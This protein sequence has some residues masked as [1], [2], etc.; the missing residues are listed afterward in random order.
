MPAPFAA[1]TAAALVD[2]FSYKYQYITSVFLS[3]SAFSEN[4]GSSNADA[5]P[6]ASRSGSSSEMPPFALCVHKASW[7]AI[8]A[9][10]P[11]RAAK[12]A[13]SSSPG[14]AAS[15]IRDLARSGWT[16]S[17]LL[18]HPRQLIRDGLE[19]IA[20]H[21]PAFGL[22]KDFRWHPWRQ[23]Q[24]P[25]AVYLLLLQGDPHIVISA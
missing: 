5:N 7:P 20:Q 3:A 4:P 15:V 23:L 1:A 17:A 14:N 19:E 2:I 18:E 16:G 25:E 6:S 21:R 9:L 24:V 10:R 13:R 22:Q 8:R 12:A 11:R